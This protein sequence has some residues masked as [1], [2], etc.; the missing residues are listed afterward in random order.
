[1]HW[2]P[3]RRNSIFFACQQVCVRVL[4]LRL[5]CFPTGVAVNG[6]GNCEEDM[7]RITQFQ[8]K[9]REKRV[10]SFQTTSCK[11]PPPFYFLILFTFFLYL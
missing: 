7:N 6:G 1:M 9:K 2:A 11:S 4:D 10:L 5:A 3:R 8:G